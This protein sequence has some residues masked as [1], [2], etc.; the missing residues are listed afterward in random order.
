M[1]F[2]SDTECDLMSYCLKHKGKWWA[3]HFF[4]NQEV[5]ILYHILR[6]LDIGIVFAILGDGGPDYGKHIRMGVEVQK[7][8]NKN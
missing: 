2:I 8:L 1:F 3:N 6:N 4:N 5:K 7:I